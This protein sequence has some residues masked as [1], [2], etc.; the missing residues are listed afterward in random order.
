MHLIQVT[1]DDLSP[2]VACLPAELRVPGSI[3][4][5]IINWELFSRNHAIAPITQ[6]ILTLR[7]YALGTMMRAVGDFAGVSHASACVIINRVTRSI[8]SLRQRYVRFPETEDSIR[9][10]KRSFHTIARFPK[11]VGALDC[12]HGKI[13]SPGTQG[14]GKEHSVGDVLLEAFDSHVDH[15]LSELHPTSK[16]FLQSPDVVDVVHVSPIRGQ[17]SSLP[18]VEA[19]PGWPIIVFRR[20]SRCGHQLLEHHSSLGPLPVLRFYRCWPVLLVAL[21]RRYNR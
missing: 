19:N 12:I 20:P 11:V 10:L 14:G 4:A 5:Y 2:S 18:L 21:P 1:S 13:Q 3:P 6:L 8:A 9:E 16:P 15:L 17:V 7:F